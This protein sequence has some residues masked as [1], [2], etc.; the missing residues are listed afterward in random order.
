MA[1][2]KRLILNDV[3]IT[4]G[5]EV[6][7]TNRSLESVILLRPSKL[8]LDTLPIVESMFREI[9]RLPSI[10]K[11]RVSISTENTEVAKMHQFR[12]LRDRIREKMLNWTTVLSVFLILL[13]FYALIEIEGTQ[14]LQNRKRLCPP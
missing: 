2:L 6:I 13:N 8:G 1:H 10:V 12:E 11:L 5:M 4:D 9:A 3:P 14:C 7:F